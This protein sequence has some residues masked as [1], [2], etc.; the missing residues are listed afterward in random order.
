MTIEENTQN[1]LTDKALTTLSKNKDKDEITA[2]IYSTTD[3][4]INGKGSLTVNANTKNGIVS[5]KNLILL[6]G[7]INVTAA[8][9]AI[10]GKDSLQ[11]KEADI[12]SSAKGDGIKSNNETDEGKG[13]LIVSG[14]N[15]K[16]SSGDDA[17]KGEKQLIITGGNIDITE[18]VEG[19]ESMELILAGGNIKVKSSDDA[20]N[21]AGGDINNLT[22][23][24]GNIALDAE[25]DGVDSNGDITMS[26]G[27]LTVYG[28]TNSGNGGL[29]YD[30]TFNISGG[31]LNVAGSAGMAVTPSESSTQNTISYTFDSI[32]NANTKVELKNQSGKT[33]ASITSTKQ[34]QNVI[35]S[36]AD[37]K[38]NES[39]SIYANN[40]KITDVKVQGSLTYGD[41]GYG[42]S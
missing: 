9:D 17:L 12:T 30:G 15:I 10:V 21:A 3:L 1:T 35:F 16:I 22:I 37:I 38:T 5:K 29:D 33:I 27:T 28:P 36:S 6:S 13:Y 7:K 14:G 42:N 32:Q 8:D 39:Y 4:I 18:S 41:A 34:F 20:I 2:T 23:L 11:I 24:G 26:G 19:I 25:G 40:Q 31:V